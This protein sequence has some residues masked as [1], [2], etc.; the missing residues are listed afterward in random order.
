[1]I[2]DQ[3]LTFTGYGSLPPVHLKASFGTVMF[4]EDNDGGDVSYNDND[5]NDNDDKDN[6]LQRRRFIILLQ[7][8]G[9]V[10]WDEK[11]K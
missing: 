11:A 7:N 5:G 10:L 4:L 3:Y 2:P 6:I 9:S 1:M 8:N